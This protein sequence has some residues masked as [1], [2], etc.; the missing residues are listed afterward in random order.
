[1]YSYCVAGLSVSSE[2][3]LPG[4]IAAEP[5]DRGPEVTIRREKIVSTLD[6][7]SVSGPTWQL[8]GDRFLLCI[9]DI[10]RFLLTAGRE[11][12]FETENGI[13]ADDVAAFLVG[14]AFGILLHQRKHIA[15]HASAVRVNDKAVL[16]CGPSGAGKSTLAAAL[17]QR[18]YPLVA[19]DLCG[20]AAT[21]EPLVQPDGRRLKLWAQA[22]EELDLT[23]S[24]GKSVR[25][26]LEKYY[27]EPNAAFSEALPLGAVYVLRE[28][29]PPY[30]PGIERPNVVDA[31]LLLRRN[32]YRPLLVSRMGQSADYF[33]AAA[34]IANAACIFLL[35]RQFEFAA[36]PGVV[37][38]LERHW[39]EIGLR[40]APA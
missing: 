19:D 15:L 36:M 3:A 22:I 17:G 10:A 2:I 29:R 33:T 27:V 37:D 26:R 32:A 5:G 20:I 14:T 9:P 12:A 31:A 8:A 4:L 11:I 28:A 34:A 6:D 35:T 40:E 23:A 13:P 16:F 39:A 24:R 38:W 30:S 1:V 25:R 21:G 7:A 18:G